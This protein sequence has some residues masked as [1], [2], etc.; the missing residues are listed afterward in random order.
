VFSCE[1]T[2]PGVVISLTKPPSDFY[3]Q[4]VQDYCEIHQV[5]SF[6]SKYGIRYEGYK[7]GRGLIGATAAVCSEFPDYTWEYLAY[8]HPA[9]LHIPRDVNV[10]SLFLSQELTYPHTWDTWDNDAKGPVCIPH[11]VDP[12]LYGIRGDTPFAITHAVSLIMSEPVDMV[13]I[14]MTNQGTDAHLVFHRAGPLRE[15]IS[16]LI[17]GRVESM[18]DT[19]S[20]GHV[21]F[22]LSKDGQKIQCMAFEPT[23]KFRDH[24]R[25]LRPGDDVLAGGS[26]LKGTLNLEKIFIFSAAPFRIAQPPI[27]HICNKRMTSAGRGKG[28]KCRRCGDRKMEPEY[29]LEPRTVAP[30][31]YEVPPGARRHLSRPLAR[32]LVPPDPSYLPESKRRRD[33]YSSS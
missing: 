3:W 22:T 7:L 32:G 28:Y 25:S 31:W 4:A 20:G 13:R 11:T 9:R 2:H 24:I 26:Y 6:L 16:Y 14:W 18:P 33:T 8:R 30:G 1:N 17:R 10:H 23:K 5:K 15:G 29:I 21:S 19:K 12:I 27:C